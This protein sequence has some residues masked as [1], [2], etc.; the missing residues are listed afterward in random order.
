MYQSIAP[1][2]MCREEKLTTTSFPALLAAIVFVGFSYARA[3]FQ[4]A[5]ARQPNPPI[6]ERKMR[7]KTMLVRREQM[8]KMTQTSPTYTCVSLS[9]SPYKIRVELDAPMNRRKN[10]KLALN[11]GVCNPSGFPGLPS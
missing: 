10:A 6:R 4:Y 1:A 8:R 5:P 2:M 11:A 9:D 3:K 7:K